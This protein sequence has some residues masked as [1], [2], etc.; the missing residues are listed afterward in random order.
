MSSQQEKEILD[1]AVIQEEKPEVSFVEKLAAEKKKQKKKRM[2]RI[3]LLCVGL[4]FSYGIYLLFKP[5]EASADYGI[6]RTILEL[7]I[8]YPH[9][10]YVS[11][12]GYTKDAALKLWYTH[13]DA[14][15]EYRMEPF[16]CKLG[17][18]KD[19]A[20]VV[21]QIRMHNVSLASDRIEAMN[22]IMPYFNQNPLILAWPTALPDTIADLHLDIEGARRLQL[23]IV[24]NR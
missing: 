7:T 11:E 4:L 13:M 16:E 1:Q 14:F 8:P 21:E 23:N 2:K 24:K 5:F 10:L 9:T 15:G 18:N 6:C 12:L 20:L 3:I 19:G 22:N 17:Y